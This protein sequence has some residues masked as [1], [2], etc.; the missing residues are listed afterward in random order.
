VLD[1]SGTR[2]AEFVTAGLSDEQIRAIGPRP[3]G[4]GVLG[5]LILEPKPIR[6]PDVH[7]H[8]DSYGFPPNHPP[9]RSFL[10]VP[11]KVRD[12]VFGNL[13][14]TDKRDDDVFTEADEELVVALAA[15]A[16]V[17]IDNAR[18]HAQVAE[19]VIL[20]DRER[21]ARD[22]HDTVIQRLFATGLILQGAQRL[23][24]V[25]EV[26]TRIQESIDS[27]DEVIRDIRTTVF[28]LQSGQSAGGSLRQEL[29]RVCAEAA[30]PLGF[31]PRLTFEGPIDT[32]V[33][34]EVA[35]HLVVV[36]REALANVARHAHA[37]RLDVR[38]S[39][40]GATGEL[41]LEV[42]DNGVGLAPDRMAAGYGLRNMATRAG[43]LGGGLT[44][45]PASPVGTAI[46]WVVPIEF[47]EGQTAP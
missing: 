13:Y 15:A 3:K 38:V 18:L 1:E 47:T 43:E 40:D 33:P 16:G 17:A 23:V 9:M 26:G 4:H 34:T 45:E 5:V 24:Q 30:R 27:I 8:P 32:L 42:V 29:A 41:A 25:T 35:A 39:V 46:R 12:R 22:L 44:M 6:L 21:I 14:L 36:L 37:T 19:L 7:E 28:E 10:G 20:E 31:E 2:L 11:I